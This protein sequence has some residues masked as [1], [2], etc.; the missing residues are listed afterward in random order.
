MLWES[1][2]TCVKISG[3]VRARNL[4]GWQMVVEGVCLKYPLLWV[5]RNTCTIKTCFDSKGLN[6]QSPL[7][8][9]C[10][11]CWNYLATKHQL[12]GLYCYSDD[13]F[14][15]WTSSK[16]NL[17]CNPLTKFAMDA[18]VI[19]NKMKVWIQKQWAEIAEYRNFH[20]WLLNSLHVGLFK[21]NRG[22]MT[23]LY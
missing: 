23:S 2:V 18:L 13:P 10:A 20:K 22:S 17:I 6:S 5:M 3:S 14:L 8:V 4:W 15:I 11:L 9:P 16:N 19:W 1:C 12:V 7:L 21:K